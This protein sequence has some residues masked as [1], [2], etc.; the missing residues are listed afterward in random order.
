M[1]WQILLVS[2]QF[3][4]VTGYYGMFVYIQMRDLRLRDLQLAAYLKDQEQRTN[5]K[6]ISKSKQL[7]KKRLQRNL[8]CGFALMVT[9]KEIEPVYLFFHISL[10]CCMRCCFNYTF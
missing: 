9:S 1:H 8:A 3:I 10:Q 2:H 6:M 5:T 7:A 4:A